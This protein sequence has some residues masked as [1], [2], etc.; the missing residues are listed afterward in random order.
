MFLVA[1][2]EGRITVVIE[3]I[4]NPFSGCSVSFVPRWTKYMDMFTRQDLWAR[5]CRTIG[6]K[7]AL[8]SNLIVLVNRVFR[9]ASTPKHH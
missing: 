4:V 6:G 8:V 5:L 3:S 1:H 9:N 7:E 2:Q